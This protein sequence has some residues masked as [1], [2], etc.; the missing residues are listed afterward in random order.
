MSDRRPWARKALIEAAAAIGAWPEKKDDKVFQKALI[1]IRDF[2]L[3]EKFAAQFGGKNLPFMQRFVEE[4]RPGAEAERAIGRLMHGAA[5][6]HADP[7]CRLVSAKKITEK[8]EE[9]EGNR[10]YALSL[11]PY[12]EHETRKRDKYVAKMNVALAFLLTPV[13]HPIVK[14]RSQ[15]PPE[16][17]AAEKYD[18]ARAVLATVCN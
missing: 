13:N 10:D 18:H 17:V 6:A 15:K 1:D 3:I 11:T 7:H 5:S 2:P 8:R 16:G 12:D 4:A 14:H 9:L